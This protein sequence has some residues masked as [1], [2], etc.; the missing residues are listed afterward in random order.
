MNFADESICVLAN[1]VRNEVVTIHRSQVVLKMLSHY[2]YTFLA[3]AQVILIYTFTLSCRNI[4]NFPTNIFLVLPFGGY[5]YTCCPS[6]KPL[7][8]KSRIKV[9]WTCWPNTTTDNSVPEDNG[10]SL[11]RH[12]CSVG[13]SWVLF[14]SA[15][16]LLLAL[17]RIARKLPVHV[18][19]N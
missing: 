6:K 7:K 1:S 14:K 18:F 12:T 13:S 8:K 15:I 2:M 16:V 11:Q 3:P 9:G 17:E 5:C 19:C 10:Q 4:Y